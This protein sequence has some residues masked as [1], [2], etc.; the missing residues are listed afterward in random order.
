MNERTN[1]WM[2]EWMN[3]WWTN[4]Q[5][6]KERNGWIID[7]LFGTN[8][9]TNETQIDANRHRRRYRHTLPHTRHTQTH[10]T[11]T[12]THHTH[13]HHTQTHTQHTH[14][15]THTRT[16]AHTHTQ[17]THTHTAHTHTHSTHITPHTHIIHTIMLACCMTD[18][19]ACMWK[20]KPHQYVDD[21][22]L[23]DSTVT[24]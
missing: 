21:L 8:E 14:T 24:L 1:E 18:Q 7:R 5:S 19:V 11:H 6:L 20:S 22:P 15:H 2:N 16:H 12:Y 13:A 3:E 9:S 4:N 17:H 10:H 23:S